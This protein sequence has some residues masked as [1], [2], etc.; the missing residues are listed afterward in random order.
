MEKKTISFRVSQPLLRKIE[1]EA[2]KQE[3]KLGNL[4]RLIVKTYLCRRESNGSK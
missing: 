3:R 2:R 1:E 4:C